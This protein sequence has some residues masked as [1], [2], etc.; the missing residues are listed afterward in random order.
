MQVINCPKLFYL[1][2]F[3]HAYISV[4][5]L[6]WAG[7][8]ELKYFRRTAGQKKKKILLIVTRLYFY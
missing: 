8:H 5:Y 7:F 4:A 3:M 1:L 6:F 2:H